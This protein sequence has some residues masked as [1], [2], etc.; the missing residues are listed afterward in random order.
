MDVQPSDPSRADLPPSRLARLVEDLKQRLALLREVA[1]D[2]N[3]L[4]LAAHDAAVLRTAVRAGGFGAAADRLDAIAAMLGESVARPVPPDETQRSRLAELSAGAAEGLPSIEEPEPTGGPPFDLDVSEALPIGDNMAEYDGF[5]TESARSLADLSKIEPTLLPLDDQ[6]PLLEPDATRA[7]PAIELP[8][9]PDW[10]IQSEPE[11]ILAPPARTA[12]SAAV[13]PKPSAPSAEAP[14]AGPRTASTTA[15]WLVDYM[16]GT[17]AR[18]KDA[19]VASSP[20]AIGTGEARMAYLLAGETAFAAALE[21]DLVA[22]GFEVHRFAEPEELA[23]TV[24]ALVPAVVIVAP[25]AMA[26]LETVAAAVTH[27]RKRANAPIVL[28][29]IATDGSIP[30]RLAAMRAGADAFLTEPVEPR[31]VVARLAELQGQESGEPFRVLIVEDDRPQAVFAESILRKAGMQTRAVH[32]PLEVIDVLDEFDPELVLMDLRMP[33]CNGIELTTLIRERD[34]YVDVPIVFLSGE[35]SAE[36]R[37]DALA[38]GGDDYLEKPIKP[39]FLLSAVTNRV[40]RARAVRQRGAGRPMAERT[41][42]LYDRTRLID[43]IGEVLAGAGATTPGGI[44]FLIVDGAQALR[45]RLGLMAFDRAMQQAGAMLAESLAAGDLAARFGDSSFLVLAPTADRAALSELA[46]RL[47]RSFAEKLVES[48]VGS[49][50]LAASVGIA[51]FAQGWRDAAAI[52]NG[53]ERAATRARGLAGDRIVISTGPEA[54]QA[55]D[56]DAPLRNA[57]AAALESG[58]LQLMYQPIASLQGRTDEL[59]QVLLRLRDANGRRYSAAEIVPLAERHGLIDALDRSVLARCATVLGER[60]AGGRRT[61]LV[62]SQSIHVLED[63]ERLDWL[64]GE[65]VARGLDPS[66]LVLEL[67]HDDVVPRLAEAGAWLGAARAA[68][69]RTAI[70]AF[71]PNPAALKSLERLPIDV[72]RVGGRFVAQLDGDRSKLL[73]DLVEFAHGR[74][75]IVVAPMVEDARTAAILWGAGV[76]GIQGDFVQAAGPVL[77]FDFRAATL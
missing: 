28:I 42:V 27:A 15:D 6:P 41:A 50:T 21:R 25:D 37:Y 16:L 29:T 23:E 54:A 10:S 67:R 39:K 11:P 32:D 74:G 20:S 35:Q 18:G 51:T 72:L 63:R 36:R 77:D 46:M 61:A 34:R 68:G 7:R 1:W 48:E 76:D 59:F 19:A 73:A 52:V 49:L 22:A 60:A 8:S 26:G 45:D 55:A 71:E 24:G 14:R 44:L 4:T 58:G 5:E 66:Q 57:V 3:L 40:R 17:E 43:R 56:A 64:L 75:A 31:Q 70:G 30:T 65:V 53:A 12:P 2:V 33:G 69:F 47:A 9:A 38:V 62:I 13:G